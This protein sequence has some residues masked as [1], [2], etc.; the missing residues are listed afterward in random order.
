MIGAGAVGC[1]IAGSLVVATRSDDP[2]RG[3]VAICGGLASGRYDGV[4]YT[5]SFVAEMKSAANAAR[6]LP[7]WKAVA[8]DL[9]R[10]AEFG[11]TTSVAR[12]GVDEDAW[13]RAFQAVVRDC[14]RA[15]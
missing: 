10:L 6:R 5:A 13:A 11:P 3:V 4:S 1:V 12:K 2:A 9:T 8:D 7:R 14:K 15:Q